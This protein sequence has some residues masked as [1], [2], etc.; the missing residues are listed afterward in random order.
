MS[1]AVSFELLATTREAARKIEDI[2][3]TLA[4][5]ISK[6][7]SEPESETMW[8]KDKRSPQCGVKTT[9]TSGRRNWERKF[10]FGILGLR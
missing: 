4:I 2:R 10:L 9:V 7:R 8:K 3:R 5:A 6:P 1:P